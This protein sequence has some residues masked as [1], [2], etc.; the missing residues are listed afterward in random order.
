[1]AEAASEAAA[2]EAAS[3]AAADSG[4]TTGGWLGLALAPAGASISGGSKY[5]FQLP[6]PSEGPSGFKPSLTDQAQ[7][8]LFVLDFAVLPRHDAKPDSGG[9]A[10]GGASGAATPESTTA[11]ARTK[12]AEGSSSSSGGGSSGGSQQ[13]QQQQHGSSSANSWVMTVEGTVSSPSPECLGN[14]QLKLKADAF[15]IDWEATYNKAINYSLLMTIVCLAQIALLFRQLH[16][17]RTQAAAS[18]VSLLCI[19]QQSL[20]DALLCIVHLLLCAAVQPL[21]AAFA[22]VAFFKLVIFCIVEMK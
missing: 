14:A 15:R 11:D 2:S 3:E 8:C 9:G 12:A 20:L 13:Q 6:I 17:T 21:F 5:A 22:T 4:S 7:D 1:M 19:A 10:S 16:F 18:R